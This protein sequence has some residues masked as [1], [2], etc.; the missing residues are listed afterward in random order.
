VSQAHAVNAGLKLY[1]SEHR[2]CEPALNID[3]GP[4]SNRD[5][6]LPAQVLDPT[7]KTATSA[8]SCSTPIP[9]KPGQSSAPVH[10]H[11]GFHAVRVLGNQGDELLIRP[12]LERWSSDLCHPTAIEQP[13]QRGRRCIG[14]DLDPDDRCGHRDSSHWLLQRGDAVPSCGGELLEHPT[15]PQGRGA[16]RRAPPRAMPRSPP[17]LS[18]PGDQ[19]RPS[20]CSM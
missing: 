17:G 5:P 13:R 7:W 14:L 10:R 8:W 15:T 12:P 4:A 1:Q 2:C 9:C 16:R 3:Q 20:R 18:S 11:R 19:G 6:L